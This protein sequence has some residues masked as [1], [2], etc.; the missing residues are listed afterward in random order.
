MHGE[1]L[2]GGGPPL[3]AGAELSGARRTG[4]AELLAR[5]RPRH[6]N[7]AVEPA[8]EGT[9]VR[10]GRAYALPHVGRCAA[11]VG[12]HTLPSRWMAGQVD[13]TSLKLNCL[14]D[15]V[16]FGHGMHGICTNKV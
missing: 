12:S 11:A 5:G 13:P 1:L 16:C 4:V 10:R 7:A 9:R 2:L 6:A 15:T 14:N 3:V 8:P